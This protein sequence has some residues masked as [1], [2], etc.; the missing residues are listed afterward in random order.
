MDLGEVGPV[1]MLW[2]AS[3]RDDASR[4]ARLSPR[5]AT[6]E[7]GKLAYRIDAEMKGG[8]ASSDTA[9]AAAPPAPR[10]SVVNVPRGTSP[11]ASANPGDKDS[12]DE[13]LRK[14]TDRLRRV[15]PNA[16]FYGAR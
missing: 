3:H 6:L 1:T 11:A 5:A 13:W 10:P 8:A 14:E 9:P 7:I 12:V 16:R 15:N 2:L 4:I